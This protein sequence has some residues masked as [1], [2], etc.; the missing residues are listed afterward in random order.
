MQCGH[1]VCCGLAWGHRLVSDGRYR[2]VGSQQLPS[3]LVYPKQAGDGA[4]GVGTLASL[5]GAAVF[6]VAGW[7]CGVPA[8]E[9]YFGGFSFPLDRYGI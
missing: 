5:P 7:C 3:T 4:W 9:Y 2:D 1:A 8:L 6:T